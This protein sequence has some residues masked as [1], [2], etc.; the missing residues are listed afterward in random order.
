MDNQG[1]HSGFAREW[2]AFLERNS[3][4]SIIVKQLMLRTGLKED[5]VLF[6]L[7]AEW[8]R[9]N[10]LIETAAAA[11]QTGPSGSLVHKHVVDV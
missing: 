9:T 2:R 5:E 7:I 1:N 10:S 8:E 3:E 11:D 6:Y 4:A